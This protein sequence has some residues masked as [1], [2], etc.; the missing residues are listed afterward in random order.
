MP[1]LFDDGV[2]AGLEKMIVDNR[3]KGERGHATGTLEGFRDNALNGIQQFLGRHCPQFSQRGRTA[4]FN[5]FFPIFSASA[6]VRSRF[7]PLS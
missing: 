5:K 1:S 6:R 7:R 2:V 4:D 3:R